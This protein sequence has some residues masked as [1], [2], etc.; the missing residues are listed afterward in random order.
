MSYHICLL[1]AITQRPLDIYKK[2]LIQG[3]TFVVCETTMAELS[4]TYNYG[5]QF[6]RVMG[7]K[8]IRTIYGLTGAES[9]AILE[10]AIIQLG[11]DE[12]ENYLDPTEGNVKKALIELH[13]MAKMRPNGIWSGN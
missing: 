9:V 5:S 12:S 10:D 13:R 1:D 2:H 11:D 3:E 7:D 8:G 6:F 4:M